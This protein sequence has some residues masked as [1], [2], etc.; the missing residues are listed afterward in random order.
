[1]VA[2]CFAGCGDASGSGDGSTAGSDAASDGTEGTE[3]VADE[4]VTNT[5]GDAN[6]THLDLWTFVG[7]HADYYGAMV[8]SWNEKNPDKTIELTATT[9][10]YSDMHN[11]LLMSFSAGSG[12][13]DIC[14][15][16]LGQFPN[17]I[18]G[19]EQ[20][21]TPLNDAAAE[22][23]PDMVMS[24]METY[25]DGNGNYYGAPFHV[26][27]TV[28]YWNMAALEAAGIT[29]DDVKAV[30]TWDDYEALGLKYKEAVPDEG[31]YF[32]G[33][34]TGG[35]DILWLAMAEYGEDWTGGIG[36]TPNVN[37][38]SVQNML[39]YE[40]RWLEEGIA[41][42]TPGGQ[43]DTDAGFQTLLDGDIVAFPKA[44]W[45]MS[46]FKNYMSD[47]EGQWLI[48]PCP[49]FEEGEIQIK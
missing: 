18:A 40:Q 19:A 15:V 21:L 34:D 5:Y 35:T 36:G 20:W 26:G 9:Y 17:V 43:I 48:T 44:M 2:I 22:Y 23:L 49:V 3:A 8:E 46:R 13:P 28:M 29:E 1:M 11:K 45:Y 33:V 39:T 4:V 24:R 7:A 14:D 27:A 42:T 12:A 6:G 47:M 37:I 38:E 25:G 31:K 30:K 10:P 16:E 41:E 32:T